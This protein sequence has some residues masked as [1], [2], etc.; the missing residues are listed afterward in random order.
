MPVDLMQLPVEIVQSIGVPLELRD[1]CSLRLV[2]REMDKKIKR[3]FGHAAFSLVRLDLSPKSLQR[4]HDIADSPFADCVLAL[5][6]PHAKGELGRG[7]LCHRYPSGNLAIPLVRTVLLQDIL[8]N[9]LVRCRSF[10]VECMY[11]SRDFSNLDEATYLT[12]SDVVGILVSIIARAG[13]AVRSFNVI[14]PPGQD[15]Q[16]DLLDSR[17]VQMC[18]SRTPGFIAAWQRLEELVLDNFMMSHQMEWILGLIANAPKLRKLAMTFRWDTRPS[19]RRLMA[20]HSSWNLTSFRV[21]LACDTQR[22]LLRILL[23][24]RNTLLNLD[25]TNVSILGDGTW[26]ELL[27]DLQAKLSS[28]KSLSLWWLR[29]NGDTLDEEYVTFSGLAANL[30]APGSDRQYDID[31]DLVSDSR[32]LNALDR[33]IELQW[34]AD[35][36]VGASYTGVGMRHFLDALLDTIGVEEK[37]DA[38]EDTLDIRESWITCRIFC[39]ASPLMIGSHTVLAMK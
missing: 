27:I 1:L 30:I 6:V 18:M 32:L 23:L 17:R 15:A 11:H 12:P 16:I 4:L 22:M 13:P 9:K 36:V 33:P 39:T 5:H 31:G 8:V 26:I 21:S 19:L 7:Y 25:L 20:A 35:C 34:W 10:H 37:F 24:S 38:L 3:Q 14:K 29:Q 28:L 2:C